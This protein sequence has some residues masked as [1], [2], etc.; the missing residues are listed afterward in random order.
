MVKKG[1]RNSEF[2]TLPE[3]RQVNPERLP[4]EIHN[5]DSLPS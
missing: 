2:K 4:R 5:S 1:E 3:K